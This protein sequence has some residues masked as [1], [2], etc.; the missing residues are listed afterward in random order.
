MHE[1]A[2]TGKC[3]IA[4]AGARESVTSELESR[5]HLHVYNR[6][7]RRHGRRMQTG[8]DGLET[9]SATQMDDA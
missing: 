7:A 4:A 6:L 8:G 1:R 3:P 5:A 2:C 9:G